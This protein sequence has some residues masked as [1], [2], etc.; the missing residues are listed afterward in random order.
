MNQFLEKVKNYISEKQLGYDVTI[1]NKLI[2]KNLVLEN[3]NGE[4]YTVKI[5]TIKFIPP[6][7][8]SFC[9]SATLFARINPETQPEQ[10]IEHIL[11]NIATKKTSLKIK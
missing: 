8:R 5:E 1:E 4:K 2:Y 7:N 6:A 11:S 10:W 3:A 9:H